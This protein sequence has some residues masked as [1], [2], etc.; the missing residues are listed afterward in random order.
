[1]WDN[2]RLICGRSRWQK[3]VVRYFKAKFKAFNFAFQTE[4][5]HFFIHFLFAMVNTSFFTKPRPHFIHLSINCNCRSRGTAFLIAIYVPL[6]GKA[7][8]FERHLKPYI[9]VRVSHLVTSFWSDLV[10]A[11][12]IPLKNFLNIFMPLYLFLRGGG[13]IKSNY[14]SSSNAVSD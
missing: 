11:S 12:S 14:N 13:G 4:F 3:L 7:L 5:N 8:S 6:L 9:A 10:G 1:M 2:F